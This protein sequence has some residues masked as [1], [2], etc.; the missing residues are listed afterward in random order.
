MLYRLQARIGAYNI[1]DL[2]ECYDL[3]KR[4]CRRSP[5][6]S[7]DQYFQSCS[8]TGN[9]YDNEVNEDD[10]YCSG[11]SK[12]SCKRSPGCEYDKYEGCVTSDLDIDEGNDNDGD[13]A[14]NDEEKLRELTP[15]DPNMEPPKGWEKMKRTRGGR[16]GMHISCACL[17]PL[18]WWSDSEGG[19]FCWCI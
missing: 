16:S 13:F 18:P 12:R 7:Y 19:F 1:N 4:A 9:N 14:D 2:E 6:C 5:G 11:L 8:P 17:L 15:P 10:N 3:S